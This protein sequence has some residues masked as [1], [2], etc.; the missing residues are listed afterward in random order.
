MREMIIEKRTVKLEMVLLFLSVINL[1]AQEKIRKVDKDTLFFNYDHSYLIKTLPDFNLVC[2]TEETNS[3]SLNTSLNFK[4]EEIG[5]I[6]TNNVLNLK[7]YLQRKGLYNEK[8]LLYRHQK[9]F[10]KFSSNVVILID[11]TNSETNKFYKAS[12]IIGVE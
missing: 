6:K 9:I 10:D 4:L 3:T 2:I 5:I 1:F 7:R 11:T 12:A 8:H